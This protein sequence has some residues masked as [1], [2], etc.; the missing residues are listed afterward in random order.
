MTRDTTISADNPRRGE[1][2]KL[3]PDIRTLMV[4]ATQKTS[5]DRRERRAAARSRAE[6]TRLR[7]VDKGRVRDTMVLWALAI[8]IASLWLFAGMMLYL[9]QGF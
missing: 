6:A 3:S 4:T 5:E 7:K 2:E 9:H 1:Y 8:L